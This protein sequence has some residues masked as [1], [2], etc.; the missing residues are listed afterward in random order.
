M[1]R[2]VNYCG[3]EIKIPSP[4]ILTQWTYDVMRN[5]NSV[6]EENTIECSYA[7]PMSCFRLLP[8]NKNPNTNEYEFVVEV[9]RMINGVVKEDVVRKATYSFPTL[10]EEFFIRKFYITNISLLS[11]LVKEPKDTSSKKVENNVIRVKSVKSDNNGGTDMI[12]YKDLI[13]KFCEV[14]DVNFRVKCKGTVAGVDEHGWYLKTTDG[15]I[16][17]CS[18]TDCIFVKE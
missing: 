6:A 9:K 5:A 8:P 16:Y 10:V 15:F 1:E 4:F 13:G 3:T 14:R 7:A 11:S 2:T 18:K 17:V 12:T